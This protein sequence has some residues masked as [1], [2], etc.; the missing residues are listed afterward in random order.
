MEAYQKSTD[1][2]PRSV[3]S[4]RWNQTAVDYAFTRNAPGRD[5]WQSAVYI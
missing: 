1:P 2:F 4:L 5:L 3:T